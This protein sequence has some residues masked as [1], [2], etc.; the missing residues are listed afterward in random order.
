MIRL[1]LLFAVLAPAGAQQ[2]YDLLLKNGNVIDPA[3][4]R[5]GRMD[6]AVTG[7]RIARVAPGLPAAHARVAIDASDYYVTPGLV[8]IHTHFYA[9]AEL[10][11]Q[12]DHNLLPN[13]V[14]TA[15]DAGGADGKTFEDFKRKVIDP[16]KT[17]VLAFL[18]VA[19]DLADPGPAVRVIRKY[20]ET[21]VG[22]KATA[23]ASDLAVKAA[24]LS[25][26][27]V[28]VDLQPESTGEYRNLILKRLRPGDI[29]TQI[30][31]RLAPVLD[32]GNNVQP[33]MGEARQRGV[34]F[35]VGHGSSGFWF[36]IAVPA[37]GQGFLPDTISTG[38]D[39]ESALL[40]RA[41]MMDVLSKF[42]SIGLTLEQVVERSTAKPA[43]AIRRPDL[44][45]LSE[46]AI[47]DIALLQLQ[48]GSF[49]YLDS[50][51]GKLLGDR[52]L[53]CVLTIRNGAIVWDSEGLSAPDWM[54]AGPY[55]NF[56]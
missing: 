20:R 19:G 34:L 5:A 47:A 45:T 25:G 39:R 42:L 29:Q 11:L 41:T 24:E 8:D 9:G 55:S 18:N 56:K 43:R 49:G 2:V 13:G 15:V 27:V 38:L 31:S 12:P 35:D 1:F 36:R 28:M 32:A 14:T 33:W 3:N 7:T 44:G 48:K 37:I 17:R 26:T 51:H 21:I 54:K 6:V 23:D 22:I 4:R 50:G 10:N 16:A 53:R 52:K 30:Y 46:G 40:P